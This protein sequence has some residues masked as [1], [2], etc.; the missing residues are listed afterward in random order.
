MRVSMETQTDT[1]YDA[2]LFRVHD[3]MCK[4]GGDAMSVVSIVHNCVPTARVRSVLERLVRDD[5]ELDLPMNI[6]IPITALL[7]PYGLLEGVM[8]CM[9][10]S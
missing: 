9:K 6:R 8:R 1:E 2:V 3:S 10:P 5:C 7:E 4:N